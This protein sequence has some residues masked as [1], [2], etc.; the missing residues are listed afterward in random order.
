MS[1]GMGGG[2]MMPPVSGEQLSGSVVQSQFDPQMA[3]NL[4]EL[5]F[6]DVLQWDYSFPSVHSASFF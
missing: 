5:I 1:T 6:S 3:Q 2:A 4:E